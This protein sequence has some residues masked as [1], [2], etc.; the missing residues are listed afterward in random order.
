MANER[1]P[2]VSVVVPIYNV[3]QYL[4]KCLDSLYR[5]TLQ[6]IEVI[7]VNDGSTDGSEEIMNA[8]AQRDPARFKAVNKPNGGL[9]DARN[10]GMQHCQGEYLAFVDSDDYVDENMLKSMYDVAVEKNSDLVTC[11][12]YEVY[13]SKLKRI[14]FA[15][16]E[17]E[18]VAEI[19]RH[20]NVHAWNKLIRRSLVLQHGLTFPVGKH[21][22][23]VAFT[24]SLM[25]YAQR[26]QHVSMPFNY[27]LQ[28]EGSIM[29]KQTAKVCDIFDV[30]AILRDKYKENDELQ[31][32]A[33]TLEFLHARY[34]LN[35]SFMRVC[36]IEERKLRHQIARRTMTE[37]KKYYPNWYRNEYLRSM[38]LTNR[39]NMTMLRLFPAVF[40]SDVY[41]TLLRNV[42]KC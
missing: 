35:S 14:S 21:Y 32:F 25:L 39:V 20:I 34:Y 27:Y 37:L 31:E 38:P 6:N 10:V 26:P 33:S 28:R 41:S 3:K 23:D 19:I 40:V 11:D 29:H 22:E 2:V 18:S 8:Y 5:Q 4:E 17:G 9:S 15:G 36:G 1:I 24:Y 30:F 12:F 42:K 7:M 16:Y 13:G